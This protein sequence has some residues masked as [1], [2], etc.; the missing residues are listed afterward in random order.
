MI[1]N[2]QSSCLQKAGDGGKVRVPLIWG[3]AVLSVGEK[4]SLGNRSQL[5]CLFS[6]SS[7]FNSKVSWRDSTNK[8]VY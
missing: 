2:Q 1:Q 4:N 5:R 6:L 7:S 8:Y 3:M